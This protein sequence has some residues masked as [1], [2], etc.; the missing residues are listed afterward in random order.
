MGHFTGWRMQSALPNEDSWYDPSCKLMLGEE[1][2]SCFPLCIVPYLMNGTNLT[3][4]HMS[5]LA[6][7]CQHV[8][9]QVAQANL[10]QWTTPQYRKE[11]NNGRWT[12][13]APS[14]Y[15]HPISADNMNAVLEPWARVCQVMQQAAVELTCSK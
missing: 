3:M 10:E 8:H 14:G 11:W 6:E 12:L 4:E 5:Y 9:D 13:A 2:D 7:V 15:D 1:S